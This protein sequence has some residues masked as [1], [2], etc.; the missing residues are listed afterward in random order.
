MFIFY[1]MAVIFVAGILCIALEDVLKINKAAVSVG[2]CIILWGLVITHATGVLEANPPEYLD[3]YVRGFPEL[4]SMSVAQRAMLYVEKTLVESLGDVSTTL[5]FVLA[6]MAVIEVLDSHG[7][8]RVITKSIRTR[9]KRSLVW[10]VAGITF[11]LSAL[12]G[13]LATVIVMVAVLRKLLPERADRLIFSC[14]VIISANAGGSWSPIGDVTTLILWT[15]GN[16]S[17]GHQIVHL[18]VPALVMM[19]VPAAIISLLSFRRGEQFSELNAGDVSMLPAY[20]TPKFQTSLLY[21]GLFFLAMIPVFQTAFN[22]PPYMGALLGLV[23]LWMITDI[24]ASGSTDPRA[25]ELKVSRLFSHLDISTVFFFLGILMSVNALKTVGVLTA[26]SN[27]L[28]SVFG[29]VSSIAFV[30]GICSSFLDNVALVAATIGMYPIQQA[31]EFMM[32]GSFWTFLAYCA[33]TGG[34][35]LIIGS[36]SGVTVMGLEKIEFGYYLKKFTPLAIAGY[37]AGAGVYL[38]LFA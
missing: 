19:A 22:F 23:V 15:G 20:I 8:F 37:L 24:K 21:V 6:S 14:L 31:G 29:N 25:S 7:S 17:A 9:N 28:S 2:M 30:L 13:N 36:A 10:L 5:F 27:G 34:S 16:L 1:L 26:L 12:L 38:L 4:L 18:L 11:M 35:I 32:N 33:V 3:N